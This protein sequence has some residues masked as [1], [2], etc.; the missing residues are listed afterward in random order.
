MTSTTD[1]SFYKLSPLKLGYEVFGVNLSEES[2]PEVIEAIKKDV[3]KHRLLIFRFV[4]SG[5]LI[6]GQMEDKQLVQF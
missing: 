6:F 2:R 3:T 4:L 1:N 5:S